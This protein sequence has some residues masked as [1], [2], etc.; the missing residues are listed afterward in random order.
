MNIRWLRAAIALWAVLSVGAL[1]A[2]DSPEK[3]KGTKAKSLPATST[4]EK[5]QLVVKVPIGEQ[6]SPAATFVVSLTPATARVG[7]VVQMKIEAAIADGWHINAVKVHKDTF[8]LPTT[9]ELTSKNL[10]P[11]GGAFQS[12][13]APKLIDAAGVKQLSHSGNVSWTRNYR[14][15]DSGLKK[16]EGWIQF[17]AC[18]DEKCLPPQKLKFSL[19]GKRS[20]KPTANAVNEAN[21]PIGDPIQ[22]TLQPCKRTRPRAKLSIAGL[23]FGSRTDQL[24]FEGQFQHEDNTF[25]IYLPSGSRYKLKNTG[26]GNGRSENNATHIS[27]DHNGDGSIAA[28]ETHPANLPFRIADS[29]YQVVRI[30]KD[31]KALSLQ[32]VDAKLSGVLIGRKVAPFSYKTVDGKTI[33]D[34]SILGKVT[35][36]DVWAVT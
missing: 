10:T 16:T 4:S 36:L 11:I 8:G 21:K 32:R 28:W 29:M 1:M 34:K 24:V 19:R 26:T 27:I 31:K 15:S 18:D 30:D 17:Q 33:T 20:R 25:K 9:I 7:D 2:Q 5:D 35:L 23:L 6:R 14:V 12:S 13:V 22:V 3:K